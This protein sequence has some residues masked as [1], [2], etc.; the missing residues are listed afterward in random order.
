MVRAFLMPSFFFFI[1][2][3]SETLSVA[4]HWETGE[5]GKETGALLYKTG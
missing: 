4:G 1:T 5:D 2:I 3:A